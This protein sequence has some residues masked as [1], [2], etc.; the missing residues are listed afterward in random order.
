VQSLLLRLG[1]TGLL[2]EK[3]EGIHRKTWNVCVSG[4]DDVMRFLDRVG[5]VGTFRIAA[6]RKLCEE[7][8]GLESNTNRDVIPAS[9]WQSRILPVCARLGYT[10]REFQAAIGSSYSGTSLYLQNLGRE[11]LSR[12]A[13]VL[14]SDEL[15]SMAASDVYW[16]EVVE[17]RPDE[18]EDVFD[19]EVPS[20]HN[21]V[22]ADIFVHNSIEQ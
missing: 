9:I 6:A 18:T 1:I 5:A 15:R 12:I 7:T 19:I 4:R 17:T 16:D 3:S 21:F 20:H 22:A 14:D 13:E 8:R 10:Q 2:R 11:R